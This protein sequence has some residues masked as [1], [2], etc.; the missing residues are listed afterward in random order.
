MLGIRIAS[1]NYQIPLMNSGTLEYSFRSVDGSQSYMLLLANDAVSLDALLKQDPLWPFAHYEVV[2]CI[3][4]GTLINDLQAYLGQTLYTP[5]QIAALDFH[6]FTIDP[7]AQYFLAAKRPTGV[8]PTTAFA[9]AGVFSPLTSLSEQQRVDLK[10]LQSQSMHSSSLEVCDV[11]PVG[12]PMGIL[13]VK[14]DTLA[15]VTTLVSSTAIYPYTEVQIIQLQTLQ[16]ALSTAQARQ[17]VL[18]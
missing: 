8:P 4:T 17:T 18:A 15:Q 14:A 12:V 9:T 10:T 3:T 1:L 13:L 5:A 16:Q 6:P 11:N 7:N 2:P